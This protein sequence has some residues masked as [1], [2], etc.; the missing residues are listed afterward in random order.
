MTIRLARAD[1][2]ATLVNLWLRSVRAT[3]RFLTEAD[4]NAMLPLVR[5]GGLAGL[6]M[7]VIADDADRPLGFMGLSGA[8]IEALFLD[9]D[10]LRRGLGGQL[11]EH[12]VA[13]HP[14]LEVDVNEQNPAATA[15]YKH[16]GFQVVGRSP[17]DGL[18]QPFPLLH[19]RRT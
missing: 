13:R 18:G 10:H 15:F 14:V 2:Y 1:E 3:H 17:L 11:V 16:M 19:L 5:D 7:W 12:A 4:I 6:E 8:K 9:P